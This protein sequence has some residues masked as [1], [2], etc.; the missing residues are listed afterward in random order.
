MK[1]ALYL[2]LI[3]IFLASCSEQLEEPTVR[4]VSIFDVSAE[5][6]WDYWVVGKSG[7]NLFVNVLNNKPISLFY[8]PDPQ[9]DGYSVFFDGNGYPDKL[10]IKDHIFIFRNFSGTKVDAAVI[11]PDGTIKI[12]RDFETGVDWDEIALKGVSADPSDWLRWT[13]H[14][15]GAAACTAGILAGPATFGLS[16]VVTGI[17][18]TGTLVSVITEFLPEDYEVLGMTSSGI[19]SIATAVGCVSD[20]GLSCAL[21]TAAT[22][23]SLMSINEEAIEESEDVQV[24]VSA[25][26]HGFGDVQITLTWDNTADLDLHVFDPFDAEIYWRDSYSSSGG[27]LDV[28]DIDGYGPENIFWPPYEAPGGT[29]EVFVHHYVWDDAGYPE[30]SNYTVLI[31]AFGEITKFTGT[32]NL[33]ETVHICDFNEDGIVSTTLKSTFDI[34]KASKVMY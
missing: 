24:T 28:D 19:G 6:E 21:G 25:L 31:N 29:Y 34:T 27:T 32:T 7:D 2:P 10:V 12:A 4:D 15:L 30:T 1:K 22:A 9:E 33:D 16:W 5:T 14:A 26:E 23:Y 20:L 17:G 18:C 11:L 8:T 3:A 13:G